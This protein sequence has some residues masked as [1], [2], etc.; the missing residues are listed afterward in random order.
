MFIGVDMGTTSFAAV[1]VNEKGEVLRTLTHPNGCTN[2]GLPPDVHE[3][4]PDA[5][6]DMAEELVAELEAVAGN[7]VRRIGWTGQMHGVVG[8]DENL[9]AVTPFVTWRD[10]RR[11][12]G[13]VM[14]GWARA[15]RKLFRCL[16]LPGYVIARRTGRCVIDETFLHSWHLEKAGEVPQEWLP[17]LV[18]GSMIGD[19][20][21]GVFAVQHI[22]PGYAVVNLGTSGQL[23]IVGEGHGG[24]RR[25]F[26]G[27]RV[28]RC[29][30][31]LV[32]GRAFAELKKELGLSWDEMNARAQSDPRIAACVRS[33]ADDLAG[34]LDLTGV[35]GLA[36]IGNAL[37]RNP[38]LK[39]AVA[40]RFKMPCVVPPVAEIAAWGAALEVMT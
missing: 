34:D 26:P 3:Q 30:A 12:G 35:T 28:L 4:D 31:S 24:E 29:R 7:S 25:P 2:E 22:L 32:G 1:L 38:C 27:G 5:M 13:H 16:P 10:A 15:G 20:Q 18:P 17:D 11:Y 21:A 33:I 14:D 40:E 36:G 9:K 37:V 23:S 6:A 39:T 8:V 19:N